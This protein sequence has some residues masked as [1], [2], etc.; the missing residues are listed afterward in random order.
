MKK[1]VMLVVVSALFVW[2]LGCAT[3]R[4]LNGFNGGG[5]GGASSMASG[6]WSMIGSLSGGAQ[7]ILGGNLTANGSAVTGNLILATDDRCFPITQGTT[8]FAV[9]STIASGSLPISI[10]DGSSTFTITLTVPSGSTSASS[11][12][13]NFSVT[14][15]CEDGATGTISAQLVTGSASGTWTATDS[16]TNGTLALNF[17]A[18]STPNATG[19]L[20]GAYPLTAV[21]LVLT[22]PAGCTVTGTA[23][24]TAND[25]YTAGPL[26]VFDIVENENGIPSDVTFAGLMDSTST[27]TT[28]SGNYVYASGGSCFLQTTGATMTFTKQ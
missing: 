14:G 27:P 18:A 26:V 19:N 28:I 9:N 21:S 22:G 3:S 7:L 16:V 1:A 10:T 4:G 11:L 24:N 23:F 5:G 13:G 8:T 15:G 12:S 20:I 2:T 25:S 6:N 17:T